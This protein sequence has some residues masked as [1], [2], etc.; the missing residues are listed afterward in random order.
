MRPRR[1]GG[2]RLVSFGRRVPDHVAP[3]ERIAREESP[4]ADGE[5]AWEFECLHPRS[6]G[7]HLFD[8]YCVRRQS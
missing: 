8:D 3:C 5:C 7:S 2:L 4:C 6:D 1:A